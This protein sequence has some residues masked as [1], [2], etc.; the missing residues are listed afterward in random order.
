MGQQ[1][2]HLAEILK[3]ESDIIKR[4]LERHKWFNAIPTEEDGIADFINKYAW[5]MRELYCGYACPSRET[6]NLSEKVNVE[7]QTD[8]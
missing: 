6:C 1:C 5:L 2:I 8:L 7:G 3:C 4:H